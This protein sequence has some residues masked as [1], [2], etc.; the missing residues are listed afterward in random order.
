[1][2]PL[3]VRGRINKQPVL[4]SV[5]T[6]V[7]CFLIQSRLTA[8][9]T[10]HR[11]APANPVRLLAAS[12]TEMQVASSL[13]AN[14]RLRVT[15][16][17]EVNTTLLNDADT[18]WAEDQL[19]DSCIANI[20]KRHADGSS[21]PSAMEMRQKPLDE[22]AFWGHWN[23]L[24]L[25]DGILYRM[26]QSGPKLITPKLE[27]AAVLQEIHTELGHAGQLKTEAAI[28]QRCQRPGVHADVVTQRLSCET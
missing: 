2:K 24:R 25:I 23:D 19:S 9:L 27:V 7:S 6:G 3:S 21:K 4:F 12:G 22:P 14:V 26:D 5:D 10:K 13:S 1:M 16:H 15:V 11:T 8:R 18:L 17:N 20:Y 28:R